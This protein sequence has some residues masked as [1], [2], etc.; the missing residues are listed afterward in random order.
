MK[1]SVQIHAAA[2]L[3]REKIARYPLNGRAGW[4]PAPVLTLGR[5]TKFLLPPGIDSRLPGLQGSTAGSTLT[6]PPGLGVR[7]TFLLIFILQLF[8]F[9]MVL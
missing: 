4:T 2:A 7:F 9:C 1:K 3:F 5:E 8:Q 6:G